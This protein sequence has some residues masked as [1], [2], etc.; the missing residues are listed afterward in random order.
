MSTTQTASQTTPHELVLTRYIDAS[1]HNL[2]RCWTEPALQKQ[3]FAPHPYTVTVAETEVRPGGASLVV[4]RGPDGTDIPCRGVYLEVVEDER[5]VFT[6]AYTKAWEPSAK[7]FMTVCITFEDEGYGTRYTARALHWTEADKA[8]H[9]KMG[10]HQ[11]WGLCADQLAGL[12]RRPV[13]LFEIVTGLGR[14]AQ[15][16]AGRRSP[17]P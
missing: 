12:G 14:Q 15:R 1:R 4:M 2:F 6:D 17:P 3:W 16:G 7:P 11:G 13:V 8:A 5:L 9:E 10:F